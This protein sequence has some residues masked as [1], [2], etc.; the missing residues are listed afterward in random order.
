MKQVWALIA[1]VCATVALG[2]ESEIEVSDDAT[3]RLPA[4]H[5]EPDPVNG[6]RIVDAEGREVL[7]RGVNVNALAEYWAYGSLPTTFPFTEGDADLIAGIGW[8]TV[9]LLLSWSRV[10]PQP[11]VYDDIY[12]DQVRAVVDALAARGIYSIIDLHQDAWGPTLAAEPGQA[13]PPGQNPAFGWDGA[14]GWATFDGDNPRCTQIAEIRETSAAVRAAFVAFWNDQEGPGGIGIRTR[15]VR[16]LGEL[17]ARFAKEAA[18]AGYDIMNE[19]NAFPSDRPPNEPAALADLYSDALAE[20]RRR[21]QEAGG[22]AHL[23]FFEPS[24]LWSAFG[25][26]APPDFARDRDVVYAPH[27]YTGGFDGGP[28]TRAAFQVA[29]DEAAGFGGAPVLSGEWG[30]DPRRGQADGDGYFLNHQALQDEFRFG[31]TLWTWRESCGD[32]HKAADVR[33]GRVP[34]V[35]GEFDVDCSNGQNTVQGL[36]PLVLQ[37]TRAYVRAAP[38]QL[39]TSL[40]DPDTGSLN[41]SGDNAEPGQELLI[42]YPSSQYDIAVINGDGLDRIEVLPAPGDNS[43]VVAVANGGSWEIALRSAD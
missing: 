8:N 2:C 42:F 1:F 40:Y 26:G 39:D 32:P 37:L 22:F 12:I 43:Y 34:Y 16:M 29:R 19:P 13:C 15:Y 5:A 17:A 25:N 4:L 3:T 11:G 33:A 24:A 23:I 6:G 27:I 41:A 14:P 18:V 30:A 38:G 21:E 31:A 36:R 20:I 35:W 7:L 10:E 9:R 28:I